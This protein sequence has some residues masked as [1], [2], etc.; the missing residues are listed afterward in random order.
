MSSVS[1]TLN[2]PAADTTKTRSEQDLSSL[3]GTREDFLNILI[4]QLKHQDP[5]DPMKGTEFIDSITRLSQ[6]E[7]TV[8]QNT[9]LENIERLLGGGGS[10]QLG[11]PVSYID[12]SITFNTD[13]VDL[14]GGV[15]NFSYNLTTIPKQLFITVK[16][17]TGRPVFQSTAGEGAT[18]S[19]GKLKLG[20]NTV[21][22]NG[23]DNAGNQLADGAYTVEVNYLQDVS[24]ASVPVPIT[25]SGIVSGASFDSGTV[26][27]VVGNLKTTLDKITSINSLG[28]VSQN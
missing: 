2:P 16:D 24:G 20:Q 27:L 22:W 17:S 28:Q 3:A 21:S 18:N 10:A 19:S 9:H 4:A 7:Q 23:T 11:S 5:L 12:K 25:T 26:S 15:S 8:N 14:K 6:V 1:S 13:Q